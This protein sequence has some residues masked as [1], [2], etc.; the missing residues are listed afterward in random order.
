MDCECYYIYRKTP[1]WVYLVP[2]RQFFVGGFAYNL[3]SYGLAI[4]VDQLVLLFLRH[5]WCCTQSCVPRLA[6]VILSPEYGIRDVTPPLD[7]FFSCHTFTII[8]GRALRPARW[9]VTPLR[10]PPTPSVRCRSEP[11]GTQ[12]ILPES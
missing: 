7:C 8:K 2:P 11:R 6:D 10:R 12:D 3:R 9:L 5:S 4:L 1:L